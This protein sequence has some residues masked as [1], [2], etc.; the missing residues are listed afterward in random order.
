MTCYDIHYILYIIYFSVFSALH[1][2]FVYDTFQRVL[3]NPYDRGVGL[4]LAKSMG[5]YK[6]WF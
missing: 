6:D 4:I 3:S 2:C 5:V 1:S